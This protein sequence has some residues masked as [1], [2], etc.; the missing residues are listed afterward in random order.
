MKS[1]ALYLG[2]KLLR[3]FKSY[4]NIKLNQFQFKIIYFIE[5]I[6]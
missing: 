3:L 2:D 5:N 6:W 1:H 4:A